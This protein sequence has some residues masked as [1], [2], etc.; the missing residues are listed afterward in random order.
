MTEYKVVFNHEGEAFDEMVS[1]CL[2]AGW[3]EIGS[4]FG[5][6]SL[7]THP[8][9]LLLLDQWIGINSSRRRCN[10][11]SFTRTNNSPLTLRSW[12]LSFTIWPSTIPKGLLSQGCNSTNGSGWWL[13]SVLD[14][15]VLV[16]VCHWSRFRPVL[17]VNCFSRLIRFLA[18]TAIKLGWWLG[19]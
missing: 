13:V 14:L 5:I 12:L 17:S 16:C 15:S 9:L 3:P 8:W 1:E 11:L 7:L 2:N 4:K 10:R 19:W 6:T 18:E